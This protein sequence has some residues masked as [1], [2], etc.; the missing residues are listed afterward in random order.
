M[1]IDFELWRIGTLYANGHPVFRDRHSLLYNW[2]KQELH[3]CS[4][5]LK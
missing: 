1:Q 2:W 3:L 4:K 5:M